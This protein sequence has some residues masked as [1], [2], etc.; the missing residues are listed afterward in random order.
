M[1]RAVLN[2]I[3]KRIYFLRSMDMSKVLKHGSL[4]TSDD[5]QAKVADILGI[6]VFRV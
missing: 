1:G 6:K 2:I 5:K 3:W 4:L